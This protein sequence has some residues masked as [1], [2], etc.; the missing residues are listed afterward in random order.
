MI[1][2]DTLT[3]RNHDFAS[4]RFAAGLT[5]MP[6]LRTMIVSCVD[7]RVDPAYVLGLEQGEAVVIRNIGGRI[8]TATLQAMAMLQ[9]IA[10]VQGANLGSGFN[11]LVLHHTDCGITRLEAKPDMLAGYFGIGKAELETKAVT[12]PRA[13]VAV[14]VAALKANPLLPREWVVSGLVYDVTTGLVETVVPPG[15][16][17]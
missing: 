15:P 2:I 16:L 3:K 12:D 13:A 8:T 6:T 17:R 4:H 14:D 10:Q 9:T 1:T 5:L 11:L 7:P